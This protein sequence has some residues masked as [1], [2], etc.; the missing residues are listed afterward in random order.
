MV[1]NP[2][3]MVNTVNLSGSRIGKAMSLRHTCEGLSRLGKLRRED[4][5]QMWVT[6]AQAGSWTG[7]KKEV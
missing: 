1:F 5:S 7:L 6:P 2:P 3:G 4:P